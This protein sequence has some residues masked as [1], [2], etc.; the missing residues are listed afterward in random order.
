MLRTSELMTS[1]EVEQRTMAHLQV[2]TEDVSRLV[3]QP[4]WYRGIGVAALVLIVLALA[5]SM[6]YLLDRQNR[7]YWVRSRSI[8]A[9]SGPDELMCAIWLR[10]GSLWVRS[11]PIWADLG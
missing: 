11:G 5:T 2:S 8:W 9:R 10:S 4:R 3:D 1:L 7:Q 6:F